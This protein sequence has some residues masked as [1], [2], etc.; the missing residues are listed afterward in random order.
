MKNQ[1]KS[2]ASEGESASGGVRT[3]RHSEGRARPAD[4]RPIVSLLTDFGHQDP[5]VGIMKGVIL[6]L[7][8]EAI[9]V[10]LCHETPAFNILGG[11]FLLQSAVR[12]FPAGTIHVAVVDPGVGGPRRPI[13][14]RIGQHVFVAPD[15]GLLS[16]PMAGG[17]VHSVR[18]ITASKYLLHP[19]SATFHGRDV[20]AP[21]AGHLAWGVPPEQLGPEISDAVRL[22][23]PHPQQDASGALRG[24][25]LWVDR[26]GNCITNLTQEELGKLA[27][28]EGQRVQ[29]RI[30]GRPLGPLVGSFGEA[31]EGGRGAIIGSTGYLELFSNRGS[32]ASERALRLGASICVE[33]EREREAGRVF[34]KKRG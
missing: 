16:Y 15:N 14:A 29:I 3:A 8:P 11:S 27:E 1:K 5:F 31:G 24:V 23:M 6:S 18:A 32:L 12:F 13:L 26:F 7:C 9:L 2:S 28:V 17:T 34:R 22:A 25:V 30:N 4:H 21:V 19:V 10:D 33:W 20:F